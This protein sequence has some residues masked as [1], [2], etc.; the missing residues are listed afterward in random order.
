[1]TDPFV[2]RATVAGAYCGVWLLFGWGAFA[3][4]KWRKL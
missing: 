3:L 1:M 4:V 2:I